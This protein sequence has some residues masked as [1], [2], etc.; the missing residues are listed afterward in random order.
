MALFN[1]V[2]FAIVKLTVGVNR[3]LQNGK[4]KGTKHKIAKSK[5]SVFKD[6]FVVHFLKRKK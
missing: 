3:P 6:F 5:S 1:T 4:R 2:A